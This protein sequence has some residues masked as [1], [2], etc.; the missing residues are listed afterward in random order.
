MTRTLSD[1]LVREVMVPDPPAITGRTTL[2]EA[3]R[4]LWDSGAESLVVVA[5][6]GALLGL[7]S[8]R[9]LVFAAEAQWE[10]LPVHT[11][12]YLS[13]SFVTARPEERFVDL[14][15]R[16]CSAVV[17]RAV[18]LDGRGEAVGLVSLVGG[19]VL[20]FH[21]PLVEVAPTSAPP[22]APAAPS[23]P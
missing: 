3:A 18:V 9:E 15:D 6:D 13:S 23:R 16:M 12:E 10:G 14:L 1:L 17:K 4:R 7:L 20:D 11:G 21:D 2:R 22:R 5:D 19:L 8:E